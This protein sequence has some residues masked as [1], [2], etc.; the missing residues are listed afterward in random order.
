L[1]EGADIMNKEDRP[2]G[3]GRRTLRKTIQTFLV[4]I[5]SLAVVVVSSYVI[6]FIF[7]FPPSLSS[8]MPL[9]V[10]FNLPSPD[11]SVEARI[12]QSNSGNLFASERY[13]L[14]FQRDQHVHIVA[15]EL[16]E[17]FGSYEGGVL[18]LRWLNNHQVLI[19]RAVADV[20]VDLVYDLITQKWGDVP[21]GKFSLKGQARRSPKPKKENIMSEEK[22]VKK[23]DLEVCLISIMIEDKQSLFI[24]LAKDGTINRLGT[25]SANN[26][27]NDMFIGIS[28]DG[29]F[30]KLME[31]VPEE[32]LEY[33][34]SYD[35]PEKK[36]KRCE[37]TLMLASADEKK[38]AGFI[39]Q[40]GS[41]S[42]G[43]PQEISEIV[44]KAVEL[45]NPWYDE[46]KTV[47]SKSKNNQD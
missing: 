11:G 15:R 20:P 3:P 36:G 9:V 32:L 35:I 13:Y 46:Q 6:K 29:L 10:L 39:F 8:A 42:Q 7:Q 14:A 38:K 47:V 19:K 43:P 24:L 22:S 26:T 34:G 5:L 4:T 2:E 31:A 27:E 45:T 1:D 37:L 40:Y 44:V 41:D 23:S 17:G 25:G 30:E 16:S 21:R 18:G 33:Q 28:K 12:L